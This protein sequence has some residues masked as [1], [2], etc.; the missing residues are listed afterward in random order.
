[1]IPNICQIKTVSIAVFVQYAWIALSSANAAAIV[2]IAVD[3]LLKKE[4][5]DPR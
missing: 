3:K 5:T 2:G 1:M 4:H